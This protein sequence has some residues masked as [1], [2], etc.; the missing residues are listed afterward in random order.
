MSDTGTDGF[1][2]LA[3]VARYAPN[4]YGLYDVAGNAWEWTSDWYRDDYY[5]Q[6]AAAGG[7]AHNPRGP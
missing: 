4:G 6:L 3:P 2:G 7:V 1:K 5:P